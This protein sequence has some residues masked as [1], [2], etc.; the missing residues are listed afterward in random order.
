MF[1]ADSYSSCQKGTVENENKLVRQYIPKGTDI[2]I[3]ADG[4]IRGIRMKI[5]AITREKLNFNT[6]AECFFRNIS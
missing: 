4:E 5:N 6:P 3:V 2:S 1:F